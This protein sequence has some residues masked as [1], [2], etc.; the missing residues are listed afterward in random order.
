MQIRLY[1]DEDAMARAVVSGL[2]A[3][4][5]DVTT[6]LDEGMSEKDDIDQLEYATQEGRVLYTFNVGHFCKLHAE[7]MTGGKSHTG[8]IV[9]YRQRYSIGEQIRRLSNLMNTKTAE[10]MRDNLHFL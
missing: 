8:I 7:Y 2:R 3:R 10:E 6:V 9:V 1:V 5:F 4:G